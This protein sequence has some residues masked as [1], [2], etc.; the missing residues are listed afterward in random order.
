MEKFY[1]LFKYYFKSHVTMWRLLYAKDN[2]NI[3]WDILKGFCAFIAVVISVPIV[4]VFPFISPI[5]AMI[6]TIIN[7]NK[8]KLNKKLISIHKEQLSN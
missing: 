6:T 1:V 5:T 2:L 7:Y 4:I 8:W 3:Y